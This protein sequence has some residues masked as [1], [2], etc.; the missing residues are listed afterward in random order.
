M[1]CCQNLINLSP[2]SFIHIP[3]HAF[4]LFSSNFLIHFLKGGAKKSVSIWVD[5]VPPP[6]PKQT[7]SPHGH[8]LVLPKSSMNRRC[9][10][11]R[12]LHRPL[13]FQFFSRFWTTATRFFATFCPSVL[14]CTSSSST[15]MLYVTVYIG[16]STGKG[17]QL[18][19]QELNLSEWKHCFQPKR[20]A[21]LTTGLPHVIRERTWQADKKKHSTWETLKPGRLPFIF[22][23]FTRMMVEILRLVTEGVI[24]IQWDCRSSRQWRT[25][26]AW[27]RHWMTQT[28]VCWSKKSSEFANLCPLSA[29]KDAFQLPSGPSQSQTLQHDNTSAR[30]LRPMEVTSPTVCY[31]A[32]F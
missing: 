1:H 19:L 24:M 16:T 11:R 30:A 17:S 14:R 31:L 5:E 7:T 28:L 27:L 22:W 8:G 18:H 25:C 13:W 3:C 26:I 9:W 6:S 15:C 23:E 4:D 32:A 20:C 2:R 21:P 10:P 29:A 12:S